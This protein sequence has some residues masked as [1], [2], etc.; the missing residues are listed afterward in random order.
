MSQPFLQQPIGEHCVL[1]H[2]SW[3]DNY[4]RAVLNTSNNPHDAVACQFS[5][6]GSIQHHLFFRS[7]FLSLQ[8]FIL[9]VVVGLL[10]AS[11][12]CGVI[13]YRAVL[14]LCWLQ[15]SFHMDMMMWCDVVDFCTII[16]NHFFSFVRFVLFVA[17]LSYFSRRFYADDD[18][19]YSKF[20]FLYESS[21]RNAKGIFV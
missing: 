5:M 12:V 21:S 8:K 6:S 3:M 1:S 15:L 16:E 17:S 7:L 2:I 14:R 20:S 19:G 13:F 4:A 9:C 18:D 11:T 10:L